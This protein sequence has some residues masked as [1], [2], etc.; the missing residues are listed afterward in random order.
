MIWVIDFG[1]T[2]PAQAGHAA[3][4]PESTASPFSIRIL[5][6]P[7]PPP[8]RR[9]A[10]RAEALKINAIGHYIF[11]GKRYNTGPYVRSQRKV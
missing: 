3:C 9:R 4:P 11:T 8:A 2:G 7:A 10:A 1:G 5:P 6:G